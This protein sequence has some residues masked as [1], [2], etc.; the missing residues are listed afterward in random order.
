M[1]DRT[2]TSTQN[3][4]V[5]VKTK[6]LNAEAPLSALREQITPT[7]RFYVRNNFTVPDLAPEDWRLLIDGAVDK[8]V[9]LTLRELQALPSRTFSATMECAGNGRTAFAPLPEGEPWNLGAVSTALWRGVPVCQVLQLAGLTDAV[10]EVL[11]EGA[12]K[13]MREGLDAEIHFARS[14]QRSKALEPDT[15]LVYEFNGA[16]LPANH[17]GPVRL[18]VPDWYGMAS[19]KWV[20][21]ITALEQAFTGYFQSARYVLEEPGSNTTKP[22]REMHVRALTTSPIQGELLAYGP[23]IITGVAWS[24]AGPIKSVEVSVQPE[25]GWHRA[26]LLGESTPHTWR[27]WQFQWEPPRPGRYVVRAR[28]TDEQGNTQPDIAPWNRLG[29][30]NNAIQ[31]VIFD[32]GE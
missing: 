6:P 15:L 14:L 10:V 19:V 12:D 18:L 7:E 9:T 28:A 30:M 11:F 24:G 1:S 26:T 8:Q 5:V 23:Y 31:Y 2:G 16:P 20:T 29:Y 4:L 25:G 32:V 17:G 13:G 3:P 21:H 27:Q 22:V